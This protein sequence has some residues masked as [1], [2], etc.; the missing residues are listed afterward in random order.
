MSKFTMTCPN[1]GEQELEV[2]SNKNGHSID[3]CQCGYPEKEGYIYVEQRRKEVAN[4]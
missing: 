2:K 1:C 3:I 4:V